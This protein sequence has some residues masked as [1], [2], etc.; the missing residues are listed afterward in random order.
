M[1]YQQLESYIASRIAVALTGADVIVLPEV[2]SA[3][4]LP[5]E[6]AKVTVAY[7]SSDF[8][9]TDATDFVVQPEKVSMK[10]VVQ[11]RK[12]RGAS[13]IYAILA[14]IKLALLGWKTPLSGKIQF[15]KI[16]YISHE[17]SVWVYAID[18]TTMSLAVELPDEPDEVIARKLTAMTTNYENIVVESETESEPEE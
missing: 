8:T 18:I 10:I 13:G 1:N 7:Q 2:D 9:E 3:V 4:S 15:T 16:A 12:L 5:S 14:G 17:T 6:K 11:A